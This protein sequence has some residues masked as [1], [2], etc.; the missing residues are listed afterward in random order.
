MFFGFVCF[1]LNTDRVLVLLK[2]SIKLVIREIQENL[3]VV[4]NL[5]KSNLGPVHPTCNYKRKTEV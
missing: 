5:I 3:T 4:N 1:V 2:R